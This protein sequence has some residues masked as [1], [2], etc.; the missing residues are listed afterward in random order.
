MSDI[1]LYSAR[2]CPFCH[3]TR[4]ALLEKG[5]NFKLMEIDLSHKPDWFQEISPFGSVPALVNGALHIW[6]SGIINEYLEELFPSPGLLPAD[7]GQR[8]KARIW[9]DFANTRFIPA[10]Y[11]LLSEKGPGKRRTREEDL[12]QS[13]EIMEKEGLGRLG[14]GGGYWLGHNLSLVDLAIYPWFERW[15]V[16]EH[17]CS[18]FSLEKFPE[19]NHWF[20]TM[21]RR[22]SVQECMEKEDYY[23]REYQRYAQNQHDQ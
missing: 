6:E 22:P 16:L 19:L 1:I 12:S 17:Y 5:L 10:F 2:V 11:R 3:R 13:L 9:I 14:V 23:I 20:S 21:Q 15:S 7:P 18:V 8:A 4:L